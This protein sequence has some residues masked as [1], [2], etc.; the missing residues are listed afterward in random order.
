MHY[1]V[2][3]T[4]LLSRRSE[5]ELRDLFLELGFARDAIKKDMH[6]TIYHAR[7]RLVGLMN[8]RESIS[9]TVPGTEL[10]AMAMAPGGENP[11]ADIDPRLCMIGLRIRRANGATREIDALRERYYA[12]ETTEVI[13]IRAPSNRRRSAFGA[14]HFQPHISVLRPGSVTDTDLSVLGQA[15]RGRID[16]IEFDK[17]VV[18]CRSR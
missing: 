14:R 8:A 3:V 2:W 12:F 7:R 10:R 9:M 1:V 6:V 5:T 17:L 11:R 13:G 18:S 15:I 4:A 16:R